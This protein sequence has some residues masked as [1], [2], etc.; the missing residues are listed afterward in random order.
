MMTTFVA[1]WCSAH[2]Y[3]TTSFNEIWTQV[4]CKLK[5]CSQRVGDSRWWGSLTMVPPGN[6]A[7][8]LSWVNHTTK[9]INHYHH[10]NFS[11]IWRCLL[12]LL[13]PNLPLNPHPKKYA[14]LVPEPKKRCCFFNVKSRTTNKYPEAE[15]WAGWM[16]LLETIW[17]FLITLWCGPRG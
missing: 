6:K 8:R 11:S 14:Q 3:C 15:T 5:S 12:K 2:H 4:L 7:K 13:F 10:H 1:P 9:T 16:V 17:E